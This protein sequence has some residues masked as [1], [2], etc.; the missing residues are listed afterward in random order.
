MMRHARQAW[1]VQAQAAAA[2][3]NITC[4]AQQVVTAWRGDR[5]GARLQGHGCGAEVGADRHGQAG[6]VGAVAAHHERLRAPHDARGDPHAHLRTPQAGR[7]TKCTARKRC[8]APQLDV[9]CGLG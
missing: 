8:T 5:A 4:Q 3:D 7:H 6:G 1:N 9:R 2:V